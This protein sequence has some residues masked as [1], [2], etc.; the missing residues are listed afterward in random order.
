MNPFLFPCFDNI[1]NILNHVNKHFIQKII[2]VKIDSTFMRVHEFIIVHKTSSTQCLHLHV[3]KLIKRFN[4][5]LKDQKWGTHILTWDFGFLENVVLVLVFQEIVR[6]EF[7]RDK[8]SSYFQKTSIQMT[9]ESKT[10]ETK[11]KRIFMAIVS[12]YDL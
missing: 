9:L 11:L 5:M 10:C 1:Q 2:M 3:Y 7:I 12:P 4:G 8:S 6:S